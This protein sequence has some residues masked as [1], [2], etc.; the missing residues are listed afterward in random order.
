MTGVLEIVSRLEQA[1]GRLVLEGDRVKYAVPTGDPVAQG[2]LAELRKRREE[3]AELLRHRTNCPT[4]SPEAEQRF[5][6]PHARLFP[7]LG[8]KVRTP[9]G[10]GT[11]LQV[12]ADR[13][14][15]VL[16]SEASL[17]ARFKPGEIEPV[18]W[19]VS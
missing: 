9:A 6:Q 18:S 10:V 8:R 14:M 3:V 12:F 5:A 2:L 15:V 4:A 19:E 11:L 16:D 13:C 7:F 1:G 17:C